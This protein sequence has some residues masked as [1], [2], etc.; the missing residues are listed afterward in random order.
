M[1][2]C[3]GGTHDDAHVR[4]DMWYLPVSRCICKLCPLTLGR[5]LAPRRCG[6]C[7]SVQTVDK[8]QVNKH[9][10]Q[11][12]RLHYFLKR[13]QLGG[14][15]WAASFQNMDQSRNNNV[16][17]RH[18]IGSARLGL[19]WLATTAFPNHR[20]YELILKILKLIFTDLKTMVY[21]L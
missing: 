1:G 19:A 12:Y 6:K 21:F 16:K 14:N 3:E 4:I 5:L 9:C 15:F 18:A 2:L 17:Y 20:K 10:L 7:Q 13:I 11:W 8:Q